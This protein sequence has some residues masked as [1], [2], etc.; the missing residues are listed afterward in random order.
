MVW[1][2]GVVP[3][4]E[5]AEEVF[6]R[7]GH[8]HM[9]R[10]S[11]WRQAQG[12]G[13]RMKTHLERQ[14]ELVRPE[15]VVLPPPGLDHAQPKGISMDGG[16]MNIR[17]EGW[18]EFKA[19]AVYDVGQRPEP[20]PVTGELVEQA[21]AQNITYTAVLGSVDQF[22]PA[23]WVEA[24]KHQVPQA[25]ASSVTADGAE[26]IWN[27]TADYFPDS[28]QIVDWYHASQHLAKAAAALYPD[29]EQAA[30]RWY[31]QRRH[32]LFKGSIQH[33]TRP[34]DKAGLEDHSRYFHTHKR[35]M[36]Y[37]EFRE[38]GYPIGSGTVESGIKQIKGRLAGPGMRWSRPGAQRM[39]VIR[40]AVL[41]D[42]FDALWA[43]AA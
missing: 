3:S 42:T 17:D 29:A 11:V 35:R 14:Q 7:I 18:K 39:L 34:L 26:W 27:L 15:R 28:L 23:L 38:D 12:H 33:I 1:L 40:S 37:Q 30:K 9:P 6:K 43:A 31:T 5:Q 25:A 10:M 20:D 19:G 22:A 13:E 8:R 24:V 36:Q 2:S 32:D 21:H 4:Y 16:M 41:G